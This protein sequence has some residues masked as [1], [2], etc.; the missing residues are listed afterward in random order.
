[1]HELQGKNILLGV[2]GGIAAYKAAE[3]VRLL[4]KQQ[5]NT[6]VVMTS[7][8]QEFVTPLTFQ[9]L[10]G[11]PVYTKLFDPE[12]TAGM[13]HIS[14]ARWA[15][16]VLIAPASANQIA[17]LAHGHAEDLL[18]TICLATQAPIVLAPAMN[19]QMWQAAAV[20]DNCKLLIQ[21]GIELIGPAE[22]SQACGE[23][24]PGRMLEPSQIVELLETRLA[25]KFF[26]GTR[27]L[28]NAGPTQ[29]AIDPVRYISNR[30]SGKMG[31]AIAKA[32][33]KAGAE[34]T[35]ISGPVSL[36]AP[37]Q[38]EILQVQSAEQ[39]YARMCERV[40]GADIIIAAAAVADYRPKSVAPHKIKKE[41]SALNL[42]LEPTQDILTAISHLPNR[43]FMVGFAAESDEVAANAKAKLERKCLDLIAANDILAPNVGFEVDTN[44]L[45]L[46]WHQG[47]TLLP[48]APKDEIAEQLLKIVNQQYRDRH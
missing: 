24:G 28:I 5:A 8:A 46:Y 19:Q 23:L 48:L 15:D 37:Q 14:L 27:I 33:A 43:P 21:R 40:E 39:M 17:K 9:A 32:A 20:R 3:L 11:N 34:V 22:G 45:H 26:A 2:T 44:A 31:Y 42:E 25:D 36:P 6:Q 47:E 4:G 18:Q 30:S 29:E 38:V 41:A 1:M 10:S 12:V 7:G 16:L 35:L 13:D